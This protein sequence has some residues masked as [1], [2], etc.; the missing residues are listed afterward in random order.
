MIE[1]HAPGQIRA[2]PPDCRPTVAILIKHDGF[3]TEN[4]GFCI[5]NDEFCIENDGFCIENDSSRR[6]GSTS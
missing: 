1:K 4:D 2:Y 6:R 3:C 5:E